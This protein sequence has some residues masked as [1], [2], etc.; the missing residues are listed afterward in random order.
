[1]DQEAPESKADEVAQLGEPLMTF[2]VSRKTLFWSFLIVLAPAAA[3]IALLAGVVEMLITDW[4]RDR[5]GCAVYLVVGVLLLWAGKALWSQAN[6]LRRLKVV[7]HAGGL[8]Y[9]KDGACLACRWDQIAAVQGQETPHYEESSL[10]VGGIVSIPGTT[11]RTLSHVSHR[12]TV[13]R[14]D[15]V[16]LV[17]TSELQNVAQLVQMIEQQLS[18]RAGLQ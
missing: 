3:G 5:L 2:H 13:S 9:R 12:Y 8:S 16:Q 18:R 4:S 17:F 15:G 10:A 1:M 14:Q 6:R 11:V 7:V